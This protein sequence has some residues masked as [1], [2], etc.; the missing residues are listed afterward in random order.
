MSVKQQMTGTGFTPRRLYKVLSIAEAVTW[1]LLIIGILAKYVVAPGET[2]DLILRITGTIHGF[3]FLSYGATAILVGINQRWAP[4]LTVGAVATAIVPY[5]TIP[6]D[7]WLEKRSK[8]NG[9]WRRTK[10]DDPRDHNWF[11]A[12]VRWMLNRPYLL[13]ALVV[14]AIVALFA[15]LLFVGPPGGSK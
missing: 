11:D 12:L 15:I 10:T 3:V 4:L 6:F 7:M 8:L 5:A 2:G 13:G 9:D 14:V 1:T